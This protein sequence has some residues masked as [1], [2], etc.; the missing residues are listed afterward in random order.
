MLFIALPLAGLLLAQQRTETPA[1]R[2]TDPRATLS[3]SDRKDAGK[4]RSARAKAWARPT[5]KA[6]QQK[7]RDWRIQ[8]VRPV[9]AGEGIRP[10]STAGTIIV[11]AD[12]ATAA[13]VLYDVCVFPRIADDS[14]DAVQV[15]WDPEAATFSESIV[16]P[17][18]DAEG[19]YA[20]EDHRFSDAQIEWLKA[21]W[22]TLFAAGKIAV[23]QGA[24]PKEWR[25]PEMAE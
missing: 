4:V 8:Q 20:V 18:I 22:P 19:R 23:Y 13:L 5:T 17:A 14:G 25:W 16:K 1:A 2:L 21:Q 10:I 24:L 9:R 6:D 11:F 3:A 12:E 7:A 15:W